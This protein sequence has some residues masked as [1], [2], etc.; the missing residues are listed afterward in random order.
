MK[1]II[2][3]SVLIFLIF[4]IVGGYYLWLRVYYEVGESTPKPPRIPLIPQCYDTDGG[5]NPNVLGEIGLIGEK[6]TEKDFCAKRENNEDYYGRQVE[7][8]S[9]DN[10]FI[11][12]NYCDTKD[13]PAVEYIPCPKG[14][15]NRACI[16]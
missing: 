16:E 11:S 9:G 8:C 15:K 5:K 4:I 13:W 7:E 1:K 3:A 2:L 12:E 10:C 6:K 14:C